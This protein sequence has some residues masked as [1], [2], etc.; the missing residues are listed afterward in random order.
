MSSS[1]KHSVYVLLQQAYG[2]PLHVR[3]KIISTLHGR[4]QY[5]NDQAS[6][7]LEPDIH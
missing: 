4:T 7:K 3:T 1:L 6:A 2:I 5:E